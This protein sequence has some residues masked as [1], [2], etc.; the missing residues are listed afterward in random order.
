MFGASTGS[1]YSTS[2]TFWQRFS[3]GTQVSK[4]S[5]A[6]QN[7]SMQLGSAPPHAESL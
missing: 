3:S 2:G 6:E 1:G 4:S 5:H 7:P